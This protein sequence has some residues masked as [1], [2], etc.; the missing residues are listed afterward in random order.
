MRFR[1]APAKGGRTTST[2]PPVGDVRCPRAGRHLTSMAR[3]ENA[4]L[5]R[6]A[7]IIRRVTS[8]PFRSSCPPAAEIRTTSLLPPPTGVW[9]CRQS[10][11]T[12]GSRPR[13]RSWPASGPLPQSTG[14]GATSRRRRGGHRLQPPPAVRR[15]TPHSPPLSP[16]GGGDREGSSSAP[17][18]HLQS[19]AP[20][21]E[22]PHGAPHVPH[23]RD[24]HPHLVPLGGN[25]ADFRLIT[26]RRL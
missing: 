16:G 14:A 26:H 13:T 24:W 20:C 6:I 12:P 9:T 4:P 15:G 3:R 1:R 10:G 25:G 8:L 18:D 19:R 23:R 22:P 17:R 2:E 7:P 11:T 21:E 5:S